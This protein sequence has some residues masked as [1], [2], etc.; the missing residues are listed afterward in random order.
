MKT[1]L[2]ILCLLPVWV[3]GQANEPFKKASVIE[4]H[5][6]LTPQQAYKAVALALQDSGY[7]IASS[8]ATLGTISTDAKAVKHVLTKLN[9]SVRGDSAAV[10]VIQG[11]LSALGTNSPIIYKGMKG[12]PLM[13]AWDELETVARILPAASISY[14]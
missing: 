8:D 9:A 12:S 3:L 2:T 13:L 5:T 14:R 1:L 4:I 7:G 10:I 11:T 6:T